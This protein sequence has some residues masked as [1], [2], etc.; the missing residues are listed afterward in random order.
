MTDIIDTAPLAELLNG[1]AARQDILDHLARED[2]C[3]VRNVATASE[4]RQYIRSLSEVGR[5]SMP[6]WQAI[7]PGCPNHH[8]VNQWDER[9]HVKACFHQFSFFPWNHDVFNLFRRFRDV[10]VLRNLLAGAEPEAYL[11]LEPQDDCTAR[12]SFQ[13]YPK[14]AG[15]MNAHIDPAGT[16]QAVVPTLMMSEPGV[17]FHEGGAFMKN[18]GGDLI[19]I[20]K[21]ARPGDVV[22]F[23]PQLVHGVAPIDPEAALNWT[24]FEGRWMSIF[25][26]NKLAANTRVAEA[27]DVAAVHAG[28]RS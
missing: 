13:F 21:Y 9:S 15:A 18:T 7:L 5:G 12:L 3:I 1:P 23:S 26:V 6:N 8:R 11:G 22:L 2:V 25:A 28:V 20:E 24:A 10:F 16:H 19:W 4:V 17:D 27:V 14:G